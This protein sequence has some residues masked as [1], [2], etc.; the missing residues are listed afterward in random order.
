MAGNRTGLPLSEYVTR[1]RVG[2]AATLL[3]RTGLPMSAIAEK[4]GFHDAACFA[5]KFRATTD[6]TPTACRREVRASGPALPTGV[7]PMR[8]D[9]ASEGRVRRA[10]L[11]TSRPI[12]LLSR[13]SRRIQA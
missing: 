9:G 10:R 12:C 2:R 3:S 4:C 5:R 13:M 1:L 7:F 6:R 11:A 8:R